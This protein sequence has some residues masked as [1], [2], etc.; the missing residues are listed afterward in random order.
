MLFCQ[1]ASVFN[2]QRPNFVMKIKN[3]KNENST[4][5]RSK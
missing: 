2:F 5:Y 1:M 4:D 3:K